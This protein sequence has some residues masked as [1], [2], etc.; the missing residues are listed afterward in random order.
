MEYELKCLM[1][2]M[3]LALLEVQ[4]VI[5]NPKKIY[6][7]IKKINNFI[8]ITISANAFAEY[9]K[10]YSWYLIDIAKR[11]NDLS[12]SEIIKKN[13][14]SYAGKTAPSKGLFLRS[15]LFR[16]FCHR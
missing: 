5:Q 9:G 3:I 16:K 4:V 10:D 12:I 1:E 15:N 8:V 11:E 6:T 13:D 14:R 2:S 7:D